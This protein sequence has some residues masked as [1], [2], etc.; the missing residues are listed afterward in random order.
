MFALLTGA[1]VPGDFAPASYRPQPAIARRVDVTQPMW[2][3]LQ[4]GTGGVASSVF[5]QLTP[6]YRPFEVR[7]GQSTQRPAMTV[8]QMQ[9]VKAGFG[10]TLSRL[11]QVFGVSRQTLYNWLE[12]D[13]PKEVHLGK[14]RELAEAARTFEG[15]GFKPTGAMLER[16]VSQGKTFVELLAQGAGGKE[17]ARQLVQLVQGG[18][19]ARAKLD[20]LLGGRKAKL[21]AADIGLPALDEDV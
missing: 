9:Q 7:E 10:R 6:G 15:L 16:T 8:Q 14:L 11:P 5:Y 1:A 21:A 3:T 18:Q 4:V 17:T 13:E 19:R 12:G 20:T 2:P